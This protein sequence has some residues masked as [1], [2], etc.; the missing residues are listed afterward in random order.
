MKRPGDGFY[1]KIFYYTCPECNKKGY[2]QKYSELDHNWHCKYCGYYGYAPSQA[3]YRA[4]IPMRGLNDQTPLQVKQAIVKQTRYHIE[5]IRL[6]GS[7]I[8]GGWT[9]ESDLDVAIK[10]PQKLDLGLFYATFCGLKCEMRYVDDFDMSWL[11][12]SI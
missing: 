6:F 4:Q 11:K 8:N 12:N 9:Q 1:P 5:N 3:I 2:H 10:D 7:R